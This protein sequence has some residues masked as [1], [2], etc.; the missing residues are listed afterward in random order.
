ML[1]GSL[2]CRR[3]Q[4]GASR[5]RAT[6]RNGPR[7]RRCSKPLMRLLTPVLI[8]IVVLGLAVRP[9]AVACASL[10]WIVWSIATRMT[11]CR[12]GAHTRSPA[13][14][15]SLR[16]TPPKLP[17]P[18]GKSGRRQN[19]RIWPA[20]RCRPNTRRRLSTEEAPDP[21]TAREGA[22]KPSTIWGNNRYAVGGEQ[23]SGILAFTFAA[24]F[25]AL[26]AACTTSERGNRLL[27]LSGAA[28]LGYAASKHKRSGRDPGIS[29]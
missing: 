13:S 11:P 24:G 1:F 22:A 23:M 17:V 18:T 7:V 16:R 25:A 21:L 5:P 27:A 8:V 29:D 6:F 12:A 28:C 19:L 9:Y 20:L 4:S 2:H 3:D 14:R 15:S 26:L 10:S